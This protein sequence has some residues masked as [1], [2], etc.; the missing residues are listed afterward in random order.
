FRRPDMRSGSPYCTPAPLHKPVLSTPAWPLVPTSG[1]PT[2]LFRGR[3]F[4]P[5]GEFLLLWIYEVSANSYLCSSPA[6]PPGHSDALH[7]P[8][9]PVH[10]RRPHRCPPAGCPLFFSVNVGFPVSL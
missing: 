3:V 4:L 5:V 2:T 6:H 8:S 1:L 9:C 10:F 7:Q